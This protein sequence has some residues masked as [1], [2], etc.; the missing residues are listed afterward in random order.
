MGDDAVDQG[1][2]ARGGGE[3]VVGHYGEDDGVGLGAG[4]GLDVA[5]EATDTVHRAALQVDTG[6]DGGRGVLQAGFIMTV[7]WLAYGLDV[8]SEGRAVHHSGK[9]TDKEGRGDVVVAGEAAAVHYTD[10]LSA[11]S[12]ALHHL[13]H[14]HI[15]GIVG[16]GM[17]ESPAKSPEK[18]LGVEVVAFQIR[19]TG[20]ALQGR[21]I[22]LTEHIQVIHSGGVGAIFI[23]RETGADA[24]EA[25]V[26]GAFGDWDAAGFQIF[27]EI[28]GAGVGPELVAELLGFGLAVDGEG[29][30]DLG[31]RKKL[32][33][34]QVELV[35]GAGGSGSAGIFIPH[36]RGVREGDRNADG[37]ADGR[38]GAHTEVLGVL[39]E[40]EAV[41]TGA[42]GRSN[43]LI[44]PGVVLHRTV[45]I[46]AV[47]DHL[48]V[49]SLD[50]GLVQERFPLGEKFGARD[51][52]RIFRGYG[53]VAAAYN[54]EV[55]VQ[56][57]ILDGSA[58]T[59]AGNV[60]E[61][62]AE[63]MNGQAGGYQLHRRGGDH[64]L[65]A[66]PGGEGVAAFGQSKDSKDGGFQGFASGD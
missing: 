41:A 11:D 9:E 33:V 5:A 51:G 15:G 31:V 18:G 66:V 10:I 43:V 27:T 6:L 49:D 52:D 42:V 37:R 48:A 65:A 26:G 22:C 24:A 59:Y 20:Y 56:G 61:V 64:P 35:A 2:D 50:P 53:R 13:V 44:A 32:G 55:T 1:V 57:S 39:V 60:L 29:A 45:E 63:A 30:S 34:E 8:V 36:P 3:R 21:G 12:E 14:S 40:T 4:G 17:M 46:A 47:A 38:A 54:V 25:D 58:V 62:G 23:G 28:M 7:S 19:L 16:G